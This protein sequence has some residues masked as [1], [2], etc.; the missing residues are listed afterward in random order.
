M[1]IVASGLEVFLSGSH[2]ATRRFRGARAGLVTN[3]TGI[4]SRAR[5]NIELL[6]RGELVRLKALFGPEHGVRGAAQ[7]GVHIDD[8]IDPRT[9]LP[10][11]SLYGKTR[12]P[13]P[14]MVRDLDLF[15]FDIQ[16]AG[17]RYYTY[18]YTLS[19][20]LEAAAEYDLP[21]VVLDRP[22]PIT[23]AVTEGNILD[24]Q[25]ASFVGRRPITIRTG[26]T[27]GELALLFND[28]QAKPADLTVVPLSGWRR[29]MWY[30]D[31]GLPFVMPS[32]NLPTLEGLTLYPGT[33]LFE[34]TTFSE[35]RGTTRPFEIIGAP[36]IDPYR[37]AEA[38]NALD[39]PGV[40]FRPLWFVP[41]FSKHQGQLCG[42]VQVHI[43]ER[44][45]VRAVSVGV[46]MLATAHK[47]FPDKFDWRRPHQPATEVGDRSPWH[48]FIDLLAGGDE[49]RRR[50]D[51][52]DEA[53]AILAGWDEQARRFAAQTRKYHL[54]E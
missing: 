25:F 40:I 34:G 23:G 7:D 26:M 24:E 11:Y 18:L 51:A 50:I 45:A 39:L 33:C 1:S 16:D 46:H 49:L 28:G 22:N 21:V 41:T 27:I 2:E 53:E 54:Y 37:W 38:L 9:G 10:V 48:Y 29:E 14:E 44:S 47:L 43:V 20:L 4:D 52:G 13:T 3:P 42:G 30:D 36:G 35:G 17:C 8:E 31:T 6:S 32:P 19:Y 5:A 12:R 15:I